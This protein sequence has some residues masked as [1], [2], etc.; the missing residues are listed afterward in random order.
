MGA[1]TDQARRPELSTVPPAPE[2]TLE[3]PTVSPKKPSS[4][5]VPEGYKPASPTK[6]SPTPPSTPSKKPPTAPPAKKLSSRRGT[7][8]T[9]E[10]L[11]G[12]LQATAAQPN[13]SRALS[14]HTGRAAASISEKIS[15]QA[16]R[17]IELNR[18]EANLGPLQRYA[19]EWNLSDIT[20]ATLGLGKHGLPVVDTRGSRNTVQHMNRLE[21]C[22]R[23]FD[24]FWY[25]VDKN[26]LVSLSS[27]SKFQHYSDLFLT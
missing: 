19:D 16:G 13:S 10:Q 1:G 4:S 21:R 8:V 3:V 9:V 17:I 27:G 25:D 6:G 7:T 2:K 12:A 18:G 24:N 15:V 26:I 20:K 11:S 23:E 14:L 22:M 5:A